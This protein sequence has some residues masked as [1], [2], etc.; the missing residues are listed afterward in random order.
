MIGL[1]L[2]LGFAFGGED[3]AT[4]YFTNG[5]EDTIRTG[6][7]VVF[8]AN[9]FATPLWADRFGFGLGADIGWKYTSI[10]S[11]EGNPSLSRFPLVLSAHV[12]FE[13]SKRWYLLGAG[14]LHHEFDV[15]FSSD[16]IAGLDDL[17]FDTTWGGMGELGFYYKKQHFGASATLRYTA[18]TYQLQGAEGVDVDANNGGLFGAVYY[19]F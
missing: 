5:D 7:G 15:H 3:V 13:V 4:A 6:D 9:L 16:G 14:G 10:Q 2:G 1:G 17:D 12:L 8:S 19:D 11:S 18:I